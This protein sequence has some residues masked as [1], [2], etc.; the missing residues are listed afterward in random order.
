LWRAC[1]AIKRSMCFVEDQAVYA[2]FMDLIEVVDEVL[3]VNFE[4][5]GRSEHR[6]ISGINVGETGTAIARV[7]KRIYTVD[8]L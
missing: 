2:H 4:G 1:N 8:V 3:H 6:C 7:A 5:G